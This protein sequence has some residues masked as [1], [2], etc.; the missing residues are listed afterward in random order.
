MAGVV[1][2]AEAECVDDAVGAEEVSALK[3]AD[4]AEGRGCTDDWLDEYHFG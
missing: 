2:E 4:E 3:D 1:T